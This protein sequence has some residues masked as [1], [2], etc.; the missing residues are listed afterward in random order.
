[1]GFHPPYEKQQGIHQGSSRTSWQ[2]AVMHIRDQKFMFDDDFLPE[3]MDIDALEAEL[4]E[5]QANTVIT[6]ETSEK[7]LSVGNLDLTG[8]HP[9]RLYL[10]A[11]QDPA[12]TSL[13]DSSV[14]GSSSC[15]QNS[16][17]VVRLP[18][19]ASI[20]SSCIPLDAI[21]AMPFPNYFSTNTGFCACKIPQT[22]MASPKSVSILENKLSC[23]EFDAQALQYDENEQDNSGSL[24]RV[25]RFCKDA[26]LSKESDNIDVLAKR[27][28]LNEVHESGI[29]KLSATINNASY[30]ATLVES[31]HD[32]IKFAL[33]KYLSI[34]RSNVLAQVWLPQ[35]KGRK[36]VLT[37]HKQPFIL[38]HPIDCLSSYR[39][40]SSQY[41]FC[42]EEG[43]SKVLP[44]LPGRVFLNKVPEWTPNVQLYQKNEYLRVYDAERCNVHGSLAVPVID[45]FTGKC[46]AVIELVTLLEKIE[47]KT[48]IE[49]ISRALQEV[50]LCSA[51][52]QCCIP[53]QVQSKA[54]QNVLTEIS[55]IL[56]AA[57][58]EHSLPLAQTWIPC[59]KNALYPANASSLGTNFD[60]KFTSGAGL[61]TANCP[62]YLRDSRLRGFRQACSEQCLERGQGPPGKA[63][64]TNSPFFS[65]DIKGYCKT[66]Y[67]LVH[68]A[69][70]FGLGATVAVRLRSILTD[71][72][73]YI[74]EFFLPQT[75]IDPPEQQDL[76]N[77][78]SVTMQ[79]KCRSLRT[80]TDAELERDYPNV[81]YTLVS[82]ASKEG[83]QACMLSSNFAITGPSEPFTDIF[84]QKENKEKDLGN[85]Y[86][87]MASDKVGKQHSHDD[88]L[89]M[90]TEKHLETSTQRRNEYILPSDSHV[91]IDKSKS[92]KNPEIQHS[93]SSMVVKR[94]ISETCSAQKMEKRSLTE[95]T[96]SLS[97][98]QQY[99]SGSLKDA[100]KSL[101]GMICIPP[102]NTGCFMLLLLWHSNFY[103][104]SF[105]TFYSQ[106]AQQLSRAFAG[107]MV[108]QGGHLARSTR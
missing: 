103:T 49:G 70:V 29:L 89:D 106:Y 40:F 47:Y 34:N 27:P 74:L 69:Q 76:L 2:P 4:L 78:L 65:P 42:V 99:F 53:L 64:L 38:R 90:S 36:T 88:T 101:G 91:M 85:P 105:W 25:T 13:F 66:E 60:L 14:R 82:Q 22:P 95:K 37:T 62:Y 48:E 93:G 80:I 20:E 23:S 98:L 21:N 73:D 84:E 75:I 45:T 51:E 102:N 92:G 68:Y 67:P 3:C 50:N 56:S 35:K 44:G 31:F 17:N 96:V 9:S 10:F 28:C 39:R 97:V 72:H 100:A 55:E 54:Q 41:T 11:D 77:T 19:S 43:D 32:R 33:H 107:K 61:C 94:T 30:S 8:S 79:H 57:C 7:G 16:D 104:E 5:E 83:G 81:Q 58:K 87:R 12:L 15:G 18:S 59:H 63:Y 46:V 86:S 108:Y 26:T 24:Q 71:D 6:T 1:M 52:S